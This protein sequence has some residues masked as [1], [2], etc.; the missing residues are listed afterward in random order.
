[1]QN[2]DAGSTYLMCP[3]LYWHRLDKLYSC[4]SPHYKEMNSSVDETKALLS[5]GL[6]TLTSLPLAVEA[7]GAAV[8]KAYLLPK[9]KDLANKDRPICS[10]FKHPDKAKLNVAGRSLMWILRQ[11]QE[12]KFC[13]SFTT[14]DTRDYAKTMAETTLPPDTK[15]Y[16][17]D[18]KNM[19]TN[20]PHDEL[21]VVIEWVLDLAGARLPHEHIFVP[22]AKT[23]KPCCWLSERPTNVLGSEISLDN[24][25]EILLFDLRN[26]YF[27]LVISSC[28]KYAESRWDPLAARH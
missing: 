15:V 19:Y 12:L 22:K 17:G 8:P 13:N 23:R 14:F 1:M 3:K 27:R 4:D 21:E 28:G 24:L 11:L 5:T 26:I 9:D 6:A 25:R 7:S 16:L 2:A 10:Y 18:M 20:I